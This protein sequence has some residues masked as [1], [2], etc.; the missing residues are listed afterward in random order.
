LR[1][2]L[3]DADLRARIGQA[4]RERALAQFTWRQSALRTVEHYRALLEDHGS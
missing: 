3:D 2:A 4:G 1:R